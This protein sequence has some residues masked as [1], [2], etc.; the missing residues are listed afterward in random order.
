VN[1]TVPFLLSAAFAAVATAA[2]AQGAS[3][4]DP[5][6]AQPERPTVATHAFTVAPG[7]VE[8]EA[9]VLR[10]PLGSSASLFASP[11]LFKIGLGS[12]VQFDVAP[13]WLRLHEGDTTTE[14]LTDLSLGVKWR[15][16]DAAPVLGAFAL[17]P[18][19]SVATGSVEKGTGIGASSVSLLVIS[20][21]TIGPVSLD[22]N[23]GYTHRGGDGSVLPK[24][25]TVWTISTGFPVYG[26]LNWCAELFGYPRAQGISGEPGIVGFLTGPTFRLHKAFIADVGVVL[27]VKN[28]GGTQIYAGATW[29]VGHAWR[30]R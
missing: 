16:F 13:G 12:R 2:S 24:D 9:G 27:D 22:L 26:R 8:L 14:G 7:I 6:E 23:A 1:H 3:P 11:W 19:V 28:L 25:A 17:Q 4:K 15:L 10:Q 30:A 18:S 29:N 21:H 20:S 5:R